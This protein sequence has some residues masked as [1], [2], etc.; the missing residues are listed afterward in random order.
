MAHKGTSQG[1][2][3]LTDEHGNRVHQIDEP[4]A[5]QGIAMGFAPAGTCSDTMKK[6]HYDEGQQQ[7]Q[8]RR[9]GSSSSSSSEDDGEGGRR[10][11]K[12]GIKEKI[13]ETLTGGA[14]EGVQT[15]IPTPTPTPTCEAGGGEKKGMMEKI[16]EKI[17]GMH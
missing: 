3:H 4:N 13:K 1:Q 15:I 8:L 12:K 11:K 7:Q 5:I 14:D 16:K 9:S 10:K 17:P 2:M 6:D